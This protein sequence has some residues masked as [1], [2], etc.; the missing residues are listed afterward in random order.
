MS[1]GIRATLTFALLSS[2]YFRL[3]ASN[4]VKEINPINVQCKYYHLLATAFTVQI[5]KCYTTLYD[6]CK[7]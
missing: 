7:N 6:F 2:P 3:F 5:F 4:V 1:K